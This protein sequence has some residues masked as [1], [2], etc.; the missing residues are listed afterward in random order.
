VSHTAPTQ[1]S[2]IL[3]YLSEIGY[4]DLYLRSGQSRQASAPAAV[5]GRPAPAPELTVPPS[6]PSPLRVA[7]SPAAAAP[8]AAAAPEL[9]SLAATV[10]GCTRCRLAEGRKNVVFGSGNPDADLMFI[11]EGPGAEEDRQGLPFV[12]PAGE[13]LTKIIQ[14]IDLKREEVYIA[15]VVKCRPPGNREPQPDEVQACRGFLEKQ[16]ALVRPRILVALGRTAAQ[17]LL[18]NESPIG[19]LRGRWYQVLG[20]PTMVTYHPAALLRNQA[21]KRPTWEDMQQVRDRLRSG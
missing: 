14:A 1:L 5:P 8:V 19:Q 10:A 21:L 2:E 6:A 18:G 4:G 11:G 20:I 17:T 7:D 3:A 15:N 16:I 13:L 9:E 12:G